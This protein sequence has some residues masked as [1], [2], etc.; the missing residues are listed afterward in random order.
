MTRIGILA[1]AGAVGI[2]LLWVSP[3]IGLIAVLA[4][5][6]VVPPW[7]RT[8]AERAVISGI[9]VLGTAAIIF[10]RAGSTT[11]D[12]FTAR[13][14]GVLIKTGAVIIGIEVRHNFIGPDRMRIA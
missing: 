6:A 11:V 1:A 5:L 8:Y 2:A 12:A 7:G 9:V 13:S 4:L 10:P 14:F 3:L